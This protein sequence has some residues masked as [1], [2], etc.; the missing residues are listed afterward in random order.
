MLHVKHIGDGSFLLQKRTVP[1][2]CPPFVADFCCGS[3]RISR[4]EQ[5]NA[6]FGA[7]YFFA[8]AQDGL[9]GELVFIGVDEEVGFEQNLIV[10]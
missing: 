5:G 7:E 2:C 9:G 1:F 6:A 4:V 3:E 10:D 8:E